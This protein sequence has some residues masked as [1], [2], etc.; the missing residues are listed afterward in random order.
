MAL[1]TP[2]NLLSHLQSPHSWPCCISSAGW[3]LEAKIFLPAD[4]L[5]SCP[6]LRKS[7]LR[8]GN[9]VS[10]KLPRTQE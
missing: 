10:Q 2:L 1:T 3:V 9:A 8:D 6:Y 7:S 4:F 5:E